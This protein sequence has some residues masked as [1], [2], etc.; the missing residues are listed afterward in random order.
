MK[1]QLDLSPYVIACGDEGVQV[2]V[3]TR[4]AIAG[5]GFRLDGFEKVVEIYKKIFKTKK[6]RIVSN[7]EN[8][9]IKQELKLDNWKQVNAMS[10]QHVEALADRE[11]LLYVGFFPFSDP[12]KLKHDVK[13]HMVRPH[14]V[15]VANKICFTLG[16]GEQIYNLGCYVISADWVSDAPKKLVKNF[17]MAQVEFYKKLANRNLDFVYE[18]TGELGEKKALKNKR[19]LEK[20]GIKFTQ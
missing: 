7:E 5:A 10:Q 9:W 15:H 13:G 14:G 6:I 1:D 8:D 11:G 12:K 2:N 18:L 20:I 19:T 17:I 4:L 16:G 3:G